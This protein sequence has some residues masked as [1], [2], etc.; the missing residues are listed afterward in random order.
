[1]VDV[2]FGDEL[3]SVLPELRQMAEDRMRDTW[4]FERKT[5]NRVRVGDSDVDEWA[6]YHRTRGRLSASGNQPSV[7]E[8]GDRTTVHTGPILHTP[9]GDSPDVRPQ[10][11]ARCVEVDPA[12]DPALLGAELEIVATPMG[13]QRT[14]RRWPVRRWEA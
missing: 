4:A 6:E 14:A 8:A 11:R 13:S 12:S 10:D 3:L 5:G 9:I 7:A 2:S 1:M